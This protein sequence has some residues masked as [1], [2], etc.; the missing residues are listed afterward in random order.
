MEGDCKGVRIIPSKVE[1]SDV[2]A[3]NNKFRRSTSQSKILINTVEKF[4]VI[5]LKARFV[6]FILLTSLLNSK[7]LSTG[8]PRRLKTSQG[9]LN[10]LEKSWNFTQMMENSGSFSQFV[11]LFIF[12][13]KQFVQYLIDIYLQIVTGVKKVFCKNKRAAFAAIVSFV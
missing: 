6:V 5:L 1:F 3:N 8:F 10:T 12:L 13:F 7:Q 11:F 9:I 4:V 2:Q